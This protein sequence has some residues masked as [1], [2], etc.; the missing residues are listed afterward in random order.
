VVGAWE[1][2]ALLALGL[3]LVRMGKERYE[4][5]EECIERALIIFNEH[6][7]RPLLARGILIQGEIYAHSGKIKKAM[8]V[9]NNAAVMFREMRMDY[10]LAKANSA[11]KKV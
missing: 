6:R 9:L 7:F 3:V 5:A 10:W 1:G 11:L 8:E 2:L 4:E